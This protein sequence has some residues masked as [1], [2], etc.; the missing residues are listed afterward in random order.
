[1]AV[2]IPRPH[3]LSDDLPAKIRINLYLDMWATLMAPCD[4]FTETLAPRRLPMML[5]FV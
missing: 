5:V 3:G 1:M 4:L 2:T